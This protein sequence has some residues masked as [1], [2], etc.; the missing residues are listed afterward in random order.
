M[1]PIGHVAVRGTLAFTS[2]RWGTKLD[3]TC[4]YEKDRPYARPRVQT[5]EMF[6]RT[7]DGRIQQVPSWRGLPG[8]TMR[9]AAATA[10][11]RKDITSVEVRTSR[12]ATVLKLVA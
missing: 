5:Y 12:G 6:V 4:T 1:L 2:V 7:T 9:L 3:L 10:A 11:N 8:R